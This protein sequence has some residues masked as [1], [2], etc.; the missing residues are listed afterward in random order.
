MN[1]GIHVFLSGHTH[2]G[3]NQMK[4]VCTE[5][6]PD[7]IISTLIKPGPHFDDNYGYE[8]DH[9]RTRGISNLRVAKSVIFF[10]F[11]LFLGI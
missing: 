9:L 7:D 2:N 1:Y 4:L 11:F 5:F 6:Q 10:Q 3:R 8:L